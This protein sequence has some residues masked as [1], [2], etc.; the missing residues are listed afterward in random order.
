MAVIGVYSY[1]ELGG[2]YDTNN[3]CFHVRGTNIY[4]GLDPAS[5]SHY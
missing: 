4:S 3:L 1:L 5:S 2:F